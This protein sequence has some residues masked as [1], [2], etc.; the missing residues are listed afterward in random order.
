MESNLQ[1]SQNEYEK[2]LRK[3]I[4]TAKRLKTLNGE[5]K[6]KALV[7]AD[8][9]NYSIERA[10]LIYLGQKMEQAGR[11]LAKLVNDTS[12]TRSEDQYLIDIANNT[13]KEEKSLIPGFAI[14][15]SYKEMM[16]DHIKDA[17]K[18][19]ADTYKEL[20]P[21]DDKDDDQDNDESISN[22]PVPKLTH[23]SS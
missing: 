7:K 12:T 5:R 13:P 22:G 8:E 19:I 3:K 23:I 4:R 18:E 14:L 21:D 11:N 6:A 17:F 1:K 20:F 10:E 16:K 2:L 9:L 15:S